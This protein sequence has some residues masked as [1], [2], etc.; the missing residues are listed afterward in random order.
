MNSTPP[1]PMSPHSVE[2]MSGSWS[3]RPR[4][5]PPDDV[6]ICSQN[7]R[8]DFDHVILDERICIRIHGRGKRNRIISSQRALP[9]HWSWVCSPTVEDIRAQDQD[10]RDGCPSVPVATADDQGTRS[11]SDP[12]VDLSY[13]QEPLSGF[14]EWLSEA[15]SNG[16]LLPYFWSLVMQPPPT[17]SPVVVAEVDVTPK[18]RPLPFLMRLG[19]YPAPPHQQRRSLRR[20]RSTMRGKRALDHKENVANIHFHIP[21]LVCFSLS[22]SPSIEFGRVQQFHFSRNTQN[23]RLPLSLM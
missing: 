10:L 12:S 7:G 4:S 15:Y 14:S 3:P 13:R 22:L 11:P 21:N 16:T 17:E 1:C 5:P 23:S 18:F 6:M 2:S 19:P 9:Q 20:P 8:S